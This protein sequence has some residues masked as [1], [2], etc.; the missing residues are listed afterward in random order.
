MG[1]RFLW[2]FGGIS[3]VA[4]LGGGWTLRAQRPGPTVYLA[5]WFDTED[6]ILPQSAEA[7]KRIAVFLKQRDIRATF[8]VVA[9]AARSYE[10]SNRTDVIAALSYHEI[11]Y[12]TNYHSQHPTL[13]EYLEPLGWEE[14]VAEFDRRE[15]PGLELLRKMFGTRPTAFGQP[16]SSWAPQI[17]GALRKW[18][19]PVYLDVIPH[20]RLK[21][22]PFYF[23]GILNILESEMAGSIRPN[24]DFS[25]LQEGKNRFSSLYE[26][27]M[28]EGGGIISIYYHP[29]EFVHQEFWDK[30]NFAKGAN[31][32]PAEWKLPPMLSP[33]DSEAAFRHFEQLV[34]YM[35]RF[36]RVKFITASDAAQLYRDTAQKRVYSRQELADIA[37]QVDSDIGF[38]IYPEYTLAPSEVFSLLTLFLAQQISQQG[39]RAITLSGTPF[40]P[41]R[42]AARLRGPREI[43]WSQFFRTVLEVE[44]TLRKSNKIPSV[45]WFGSTPCPPESYLAAAAE[46]ARLLLN[47][48]DVPEVVKIAPATLTTEQYV[49]DN[50][51]RLWGWVIF[52]ENFS[53]PNLMALGKLQAWTLKP[54]L[55]GTSTRRR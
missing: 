52:P 11:G 36:P 30:T 15:R 33:E 27:R 55:L 1:K 50:D 46:M 9:E 10:R 45:V 40:G 37:G 8:K 38:Q 41:S 51:P 4:L 47:G 34:D 28:A 53:A 20:V 14:G 7:A 26:R 16:G 24:E 2:I 3:A 31:P 54:A 22:K 25:N 39:N 18:G 19:S 13:A 44:S 17:Y 21:G 35:M 32:P 49:A 6:Y 43:P 23:G 12:H 29:C 5:L 42:A 48:T